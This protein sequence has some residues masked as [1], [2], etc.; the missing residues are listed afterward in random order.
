MYISGDN[1]LLPS[2]VYLFCLPLHMGR[3]HSEFHGKPYGFGICSLSSLL[4][5]GC[6]VGF[7]RAEGATGNRNHWSS[8]SLHSRYLVPTLDLGIRGFRWDDLKKSLHGSDV[9]AVQATHRD[10]VVLR[11]SLLLFFCSSQ[12]L[13]Y[14]SIHFN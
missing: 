14:R 3:R 4:T 5:P 2:P 12:H 7:Q 1:V 9:K 8:Q 11:E 13:Q 10:S 6:L